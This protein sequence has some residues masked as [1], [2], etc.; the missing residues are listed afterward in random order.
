M[1]HFTT[2][3]TELVRKELIVKALLDL[4]HQVVEGPGHIRDWSGEQTDVEL[5]VPTQNPEY[6]LGFCM[7]GQTY[8]LVG[9]WYGIHEIQQD[10]FLA[11]IKQRYAYHVAIDRLT[12]QGFEI[13]TEEKDADNN[14]QMIFQRV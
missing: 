11:K 12:K 2:M 4:G 7:E 9:D 10:A 8:V 3:K 14:I 13:V 6:D 1:S 5:R